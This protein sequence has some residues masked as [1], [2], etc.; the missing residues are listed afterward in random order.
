M[1]KQEPKEIQVGLK[2]IMWRS[3]ERDRLQT[4]AFNLD[5]DKQAADDTQRSFEIITPAPEH[6]VWIQKLEKYRDTT[7]RSFDK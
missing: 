3:F 1:T 6:S 2:S 4:R 7:S 5:F